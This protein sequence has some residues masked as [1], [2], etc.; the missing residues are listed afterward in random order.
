MTK[1]FIVNNL[2]RNKKCLF[3]LNPAIVSEL[4]TMAISLSNVLFHKVDAYSHTDV[5]NE[6]QNFEGTH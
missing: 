3:N 5:S 2:D 4:T 1:T 6:Q